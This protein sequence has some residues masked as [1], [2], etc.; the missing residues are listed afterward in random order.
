M[1]VHKHKSNDSSQHDTG[2]GEDAREFRVGEGSQRDE[3]EDHITQTEAK[4]QTTQRHSH[5]R[6]SHGTD[7]Q[8][9]S[10][11]ITDTSDNPHRPARH[12]DGE[13]GNVEQ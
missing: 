1:L 9:T 8:A 6:P 10:D 3:V 12:E 7:A 11:T 5:F 13:D 2:D 4:D